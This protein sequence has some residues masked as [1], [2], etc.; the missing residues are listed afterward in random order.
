MLC[1]EQR[2]LADLLEVGADGV[3]GRG[4]LGVLAR[5]T[6]RGRLLDVPDGRRVFFLVVRVIV[7]V[8]FDV[9]AVQIVL[10]DVLGELVIKI[11]VLV[12]EFGIVIFVVAVVD[13][14][15]IV[16]KRIGA[17]LVLVYALSACVRSGRRS[18]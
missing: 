11:G 14:I 3:G 9:V 13:G 16:D 12:R 8:V 1:V 4:Q 6:Q 18:A 17:Q 2:D 7:F 5:L 15:G 10:V